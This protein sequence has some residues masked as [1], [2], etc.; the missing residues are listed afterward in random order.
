MFAEAQIATLDPEGDYDTLAQLVEEGP[1]F[2]IPG[3]GPSIKQQLI[4]FGIGSGGTLL[5]ALAS[6]ISHGLVGPSPQNL[7]ILTSPY[8][9]GNVAGSVVRTGNVSDVGATA[10]AAVGGI[11]DAIGQ[12]IFTHPYLSIGFVFALVLLFM[13]SPRRGRR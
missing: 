13:P 10:G 11:G 5:N 4:T 1:T 8:L 9:P 3:S 2:E 12:I 6:K 7:S